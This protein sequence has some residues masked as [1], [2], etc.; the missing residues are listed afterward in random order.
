MNSE[1]DFADLP[2]WR[3]ARDGHDAKCPANVEFTGEHDSP[4]INLKCRYCGFSVVAVDRETL[5]RDVAR[6]NR[7]RAE[8]AARSLRAFS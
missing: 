5:S 7:T 1:A 3:T 2:D 6:V 8:E 4:T